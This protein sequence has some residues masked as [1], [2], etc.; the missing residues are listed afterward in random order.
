LEE[1]N[2]VP[3]FWHQKVFWYTVSAYAGLVGL[4][5]FLGALHYARV[6]VTPGVTYVG[7]GV[8]VIVW[9]ICQ[10]FLRIHPLSWAFRGHEFKI[11]RLGAERTA[12]F[13]GA[14]VLLWIPRLVPESKAAIFQ[15]TALIGARSNLFRIHQRLQ[16]MQE[17]VTKVGTSAAVDAFSTLPQRLMIDS[18]DVSFCHSS[19]T[20]LGEFEPD[21]TRAA[22]HY[23]STLSN[24]SE[25]E[26]KM[27][28][29]WQENKD[30]QQL[31]VASETSIEAQV[32]LA[33]GLEMPEGYYIQRFKM[34]VFSAEK[35][36]LTKREL[37]TGLPQNG[38][39]NLAMEEPQIGKYVAIRFKVNCE[40]GK[41]GT[42]E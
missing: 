22:T 21:F 7:T 28:K 25:Q 42:G 37:F 4:G 40:T 2:H 1:N 36:G 38:I 15:Q 11:S 35:M 13:L 9:F 29:G 12:G 30:L 14:C 39:P 32:A 23:C 24:F 18:M 10:F 17:T 31:E 5:A 3:P 34:V 16:T 33:C 20:H 27:W 41:V 6:L 26:P 19:E 8:L